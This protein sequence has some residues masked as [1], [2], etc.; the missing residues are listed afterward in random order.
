MTFTTT[1]SSLPAAIKLR[2]NSPNTIRLAKLNNDSDALPTTGDDN[3]SPME[4]TDAT[5]EFSVF[6]VGR[7]LPFADYD[8]VPLV[9]DAAADPPQYKVNVPA[10]TSVP[11]GQYYGEY[12]VTAPGFSPARLP[13]V[14]TVTY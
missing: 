10:R 2:Y 4:D 11:I 1:R 6:S 9:W 12:T 13:V 7:T 5:V 3:P 14:V 8:H